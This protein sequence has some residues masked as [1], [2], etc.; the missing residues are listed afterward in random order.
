MTSSVTV[1][2]EKKTNAQEEILGVEREGV[3]AI[4]RNDA[5]VI[6]QF[7]SDDWISID[8]DGSVITKSNFLDAI[9]SGDLSHEA[10]EFR[11]PRVRTYGNFAMVTGL[12]TSKGKLLGQ[13]FRERERYTDVFVKEN[14][15]WQCVL[16]QLSTFIEK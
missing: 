13:E 3:E 16:T 15:R 8:H 10:M 9:T 12:A 1:A 7:L 4:L 5:E 2:E 6:G 14:G 11:E